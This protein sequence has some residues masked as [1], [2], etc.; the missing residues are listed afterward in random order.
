MFSKKKFSTVPLSILNEHWLTEGGG[1]SESCSESEVCPQ[2]WNLLMRF[3]IHT[4]QHLWCF[5]GCSEFFSLHNLQPQVF[6]V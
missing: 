4:F 2:S 5:S 3:F 6:A 1:V